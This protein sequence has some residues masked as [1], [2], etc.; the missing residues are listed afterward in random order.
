MSSFIVVYV[1]LRVTLGAKPNTFSGPVNFMKVHLVS[2]DPSLHGVCRELL[3]SL[4]SCRWDFGTLA[5][6]EPGL[7]ADLWILDCD[8]NEAFPP[9]SWLREEHNIIFVLDRQKIGLFR[10]LLPVEAVRILLKPVRP[11]LLQGFLG[12]ILV[13]SAGIGGEAN[14]ETR[15]VKSDRDILLQNVLEANLWLQEFEQ[16]RNGFLART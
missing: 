1:R 11:N 7:K 2:K 3:H 6:W 10:D 12:Q 5:S 8:A 13:P 4:K 14:Q 9:E 16:D 15:R